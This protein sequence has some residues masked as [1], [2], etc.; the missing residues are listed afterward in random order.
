M[1]LDEIDEGNISFIKLFNENNAELT[2]L[3]AFDW[4]DVG[5]SIDVCGEGND[6]IF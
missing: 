3:Y 1:F 5:N 6:L 2:C 4:A